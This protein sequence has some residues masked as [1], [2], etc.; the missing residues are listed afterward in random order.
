MDNKRRMQH[1][2]PP[3]VIRSTPILVVEDDVALRKLVRSL[4][5]D[6]GFTVFEAGDLA[7]ARAAL[8]HHPI[9][10]VLCDLYL[11]GDDLGTDLL[12]EL[13]PRT[14]DVAV[15]MMTGTTDTQT[16]IS[17]LR[18]GAFDYLLK[19]FKPEDLVSVVKRS[20]ERRDKWISER[21]QIDRQIE[22]LARFPSE[23]PDPVLRVH[24]NG[25]ILYANKAALPLLQHWETKVGST[26][27]SSLKDLILAAR[28]SGDKRQ[29]EFGV[30]DRVFSFTVAPIRGA[31]FVYLYG[32]DITF[33]VKAEKELIELRDRA[34]WMALHD[35]LTGLPNRK[36]LEK[37]MEDALRATEKRLDKLGVVFLDLDNFKYIN[38]LYGH[39]TGDQALT[40]VAD[41]FKTAFDTGQLFESDAVARWG[42]DELVLLLSKL[43]T[44]EEARRRCEGLQSGLQA[45]INEKL[46]FPLATSM[47]IAVYPDDTNRPDDLLH[48][49]D[50]ALYIAKARGPNSLV[51]IGE[52]T[53]DRLSQYDRSSLS[54]LL[55]GAV[56]N[57]EIQVHYQPILDAQTGDVVAAEALARWKDARLGWVACDAFIPVAEESGLINELGRQVTAQALL[58]LR[59][60]LDAGLDI[61]LSLN[62]SLR[63]MSMPNFGPELVASAEKTDIDP[64]RITIEVTERELIM[65]ARRLARLADHGFRLAIDDFGS[66][67]SSLAQLHELHVHELKIDR[68]LTAKMETERGCRIMETVV[69]LGHILGLTMVAE[70]VETLETCRKLQNM[71]VERL[72]GFLFS[73]PLPADEFL[74]KVQSKKSE[75]FPGRPTRAEV[76]PATGTASV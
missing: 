36:Y 16:A 39:K 8:E 25:L 10:L 37:K 75:L 66:G 61:G 57:N 15:V 74:D 3:S 73:Q 21:Q 28:S 68:S 64:S 56:Q 34:E 30:E 19:P 4:L 60:W 20:L 9:G 45:L 49:A 40:C 32:H 69:K 46:H 13:A 17:C 58:E 55:T 41:F 35:T 38:D 23:S 71:H 50:T 47:G 42:G 63:Q 59:R 76:T 70:G 52:Q 11:K 51:C 67:Y 24:Q 54:A 43:K 1:R 29:L 2:P 22:M 18:E 14:P 31:E 53:P 6:A 7:E 48:Q 12:R 26:I 65:E 72:Q 27:P 33:R 44:P 5:A 62:G